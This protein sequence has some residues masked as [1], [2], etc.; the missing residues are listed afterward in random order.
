MEQIPNEGFPRCAADA[1]TCVKVEPGKIYA[2]CTCGISEKQP[3]CDGRHKNIEGLPYK[4]LKVEFTEEKEVWFC[5]C[6]K[7]KNPPYCDG[8]HKGS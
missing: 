7:T 1:P 3:F 8:S 4:S 2:W 5:N 6:K